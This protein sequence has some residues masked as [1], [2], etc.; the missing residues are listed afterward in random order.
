V[1][2]TRSSGPTMNRHGSTRRSGWTRGL[3]TT[4]GIPDPPWRVELD[5]ISCNYGLIYFN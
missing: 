4:N 3:W 5:A 1:L 2:R